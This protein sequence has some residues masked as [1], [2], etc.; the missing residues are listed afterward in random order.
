M[1]FPSVSAV[2]VLSC[3]WCSSNRR[4]SAPDPQ[5]TSSRDAR[6]LGGDESAEARAGA[7]LHDGLALELCPPRR[8]EPGE[9][10]GHG[11]HDLARQIVVSLSGVE[12]EGKG[13]TPSASHHTPYTTHTRARTEAA[14]EHRSCCRTPSPNANSRVT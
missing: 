5:P 4:E 10:H 6:E 7:E 13:E 2:R 14:V 8:K 9:E 12:G 3:Q 1:S 11:P